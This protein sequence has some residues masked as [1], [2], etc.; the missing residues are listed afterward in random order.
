METALGCL[1]RVTQHFL[2]APQSAPQRDI[3]ICV[4]RGSDGAWGTGCTFQPLLVPIL[5]IDHLDRTSKQGELT[6]ASPWTILPSH[7]SSPF[8]CRYSPPVLPH[9]KNWA[10]GLHHVTAFLFFISFSFM[11]C[12]FTCLGD[13]HDV[14]LDAQF[15]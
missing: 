7:W 6:L 4:T 14:Q 15:H 2:F 10:W 11:Y 13:L 3:T 9:L 5:L 1:H 12:F 8:H